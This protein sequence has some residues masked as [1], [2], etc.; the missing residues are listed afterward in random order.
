LN[1]LP[2]IGSDEDFISVNFV[3]KGDVNFD[4]AVAKEVAQK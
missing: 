4:S 1:Y 3:K 2:V